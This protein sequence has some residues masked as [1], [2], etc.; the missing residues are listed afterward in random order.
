M[1][2]IDEDR[3][4]RAYLLNGRLHAALISIGCYNWGGSPSGERYQ[5][6]SH[7]GSE[8][9][10]GLGEAFRTIRW[11]GWTQDGPRPRSLVAPWSNIC[12]VLLDDSGI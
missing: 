5:D 4:P 3:L 8:M 11:K 9:I 10:K 6:Q 1:I 7:K 2:V 12:T